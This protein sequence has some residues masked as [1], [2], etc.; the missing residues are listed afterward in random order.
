MTGCRCDPGYYGEACELLRCPRGDDPI[1][2]CNP[3]ASPLDRRCIGE[4]DG[5]VWEIR[6]EFGSPANAADMPLGSDL[7]IVLSTASGMEW[8]TSAIQDS[9]GM[10]S[11]ESSAKLRNAVENAFG[12]IFPS[13]L[14]QQ[15]ARSMQARAWQVTFAH[16]SNAGNSQTLSC[17]HPQPCPYDSCAPKRHSMLSVSTLGT[18]GTLGDVV[19]GPSSFVQTEL[20]PHGS[21]FAPAGQHDVQVL[22]NVWRSP[23]GTFL[24]YSAQVASPSLNASSIM[25]AIPATP[26]PQGL[27][28]RE[29]PV[30]FGLTIQFVSDFPAP[31]AYVFSVS[32]ARCTASMVRGANPWYESKECSGRGTCMGDIGQ[33]KCFAGFG[34]D[35]CSELVL[36]A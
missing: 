12:S 36:D 3:G 13:V 21:S 6:H 7:S 34:G 5:Q 20:L 29:S 10:S 4:I 11:L 14:V 31:G 15:T 2:G 9:W 25:T 19:L 27:A 35:A 17:P 22:V 30:A 32:Q 16:P 24:L 18:T 33:C 8:T 26:T 28:R 23:V 1:T